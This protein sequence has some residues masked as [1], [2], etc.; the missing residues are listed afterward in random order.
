LLA[1]SAPNDFFL[2]R[3]HATARHRIPI[4]KAAEMKQPVDE[5]ETQLVLEQGPES[6][7]VSPGGLDAD[8]NLAVLESDD[9]G[10][11]GDPHE[12]AMKFGDFAIGDEQHPDFFQV[13]QARARLAQTKAERALR[14][15]LQRCPVK[16]DLSLQIS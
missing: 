5:V 4:V 10:R 3:V 11:P 12:A 2:D 15:L 6:F 8:E 16:R 9:I 1:G 14:E 7:G 13:R